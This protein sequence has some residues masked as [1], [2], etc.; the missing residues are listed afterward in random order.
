M[1]ARNDKRI[2]SSKT[3]KMRK[4]KFIDHIS[5]KSRRD[6]K[7]ERSCNSSLIDSIRSHRGE[8]RYVHDEYMKESANCFYSKLHT[9][10]SNRPKT[11]LLGTNSAS[12]IQLSF[13]VQSPHIGEI[14]PRRDKFKNSEVKNLSLLL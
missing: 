13:K 7:G 6:R 11:S 1:R 12:R 4:S 3:S 9:R 10:N 8:R 5:E 2:S 14:K